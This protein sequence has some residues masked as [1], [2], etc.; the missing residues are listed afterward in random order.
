MGP[1]RRLETSVRKKLLGAEFDVQVT[2]Q[3]DIFLQ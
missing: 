1:M 3:R 2:V